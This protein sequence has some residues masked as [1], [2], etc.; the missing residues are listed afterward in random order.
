MQD[1]GARQ[2]I[3]KGVDGAR[4]MVH[5]QAQDA[6]ERDFKNKVKMQYLFWT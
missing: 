2:V 1:K 4:H 3:D 6:R 5:K